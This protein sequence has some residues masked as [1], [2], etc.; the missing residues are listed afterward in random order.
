VFYVRTDGPVTVH[1]DYDVCS[2]TARDDWASVLHI[3][4]E[5]GFDSIRRLAVRNLFP[6]ASP[7][8][9]IVFGHRYGISEWL[10]DAYVAV[11]TRSEPITRE[12]GDA[13]GVKDI[14]Q[15]GGIRE[16]IA[17]GIAPSQLRLVIWRSCCP[18]SEA[19]NAVKNA[20]K[21]EEERTKSPMHAANLDVEQK[22][23]LLDRLRSEAERVQ[24][25]LLESK[26]RAEKLEAEDTQRKKA[27]A[28]ANLAKKKAE[29]EE[30]AM[31]E[32]K[33]LAVE[34]ERLISSA[35][36]AG[37]AVEAARLELERAVREDEEARRAA[38]ELEAAK[39][40]ASRSVFGSQTSDHQSVDWFDSRPSRASRSQTSTASHSYPSELRAVPLPSENVPAPA[41]L[42]D[43]A[44]IWGSPSTPAVVDPKCESAHGPDA[45]KPDVRG[46]EV[47]KPDPRGTK[48]WT[49]EGESEDAWFAMSGKKKKSPISE[50]K[51]KKAVG[52]V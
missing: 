3:A 34:E 51:G 21:L 25:A 43:L 52:R 4:S 2:L 27:E 10:L 23:A 11:C 24:A 49:H 42:R 37:D 16:A 17:R 33:R 48:E 30:V 7:V 31:E 50:G 26:S 5:F 46:A 41:P 38:H 13:L 15:I 28:E 1:R 6:L 9:K 35:K 44:D 47:C 18:L 36:K 19:D 29:Q 40:A 14:I 20:Q 39:N 8:D 12:E 22:Q 45:V 32:A